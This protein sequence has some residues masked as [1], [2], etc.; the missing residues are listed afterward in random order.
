MVFDVRWRSAVSLSR[1]I[2]TRQNNNEELTTGELGL[3]NSW[4]KLLN[5][6][7]NSKFSRNR[8]EISR[9]EKREEAKGKVHW[10]QRMKK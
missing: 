2:R 4:A 1:R 6:T 8:S 7:A 10:E 5:A 9:S 3:G